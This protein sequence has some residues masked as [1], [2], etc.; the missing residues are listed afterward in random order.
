M[1]DCSV[2]GAPVGGAAGGPGIRAEAEIY[3][4]RCAPDTLLRAAGEEY[5]AILR[6]GVSYFVEK[7]GVAPS[8]PPRSGAEFLEVGTAVLQERARRTAP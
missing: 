3:H 5:E 4:V 8:D 6:K 1:A 2:C 7:Y